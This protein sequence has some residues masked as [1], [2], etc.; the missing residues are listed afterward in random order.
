M[1]YTDAQLIQLAQDNPKELARLLTSPHADIRMLTA[2]AEILSTEV[3]DESL[4]LPALRILLKH[5]HAMVREGACI[6]VSSFYMDSK[7]PQDIIDRLV[8]MSTTDPSV[9]VRDYSKTLLQD[10]TIK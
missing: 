1:N 2:G 4:V 6:G 7:P 3:K 5:K 10:F 8:V 9:V